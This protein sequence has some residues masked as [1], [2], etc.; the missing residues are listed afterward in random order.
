MITLLIHLLSYV[1]CRCDRDRHGGGIL[2]LVRD[3]LS[4]IR[5]SDCELLWLE[6]FTHVGPVL[7]GTFYHSPNSDESSLTILNSSLLSIHSGHHIVLCG[8]FN[9]PHINWSTVTPTVSSPC[10]TFLCS[11]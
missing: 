8:D 7:F 3:H 6:V 4:V 2:V 11:L 9:F 5:R 10:A 1:G